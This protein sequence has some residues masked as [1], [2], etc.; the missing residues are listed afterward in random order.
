MNAHPQCGAINRKW[1]IWLAIP[2]LLVLLFAGYWGVVKYRHQHAR[3]IWK[4]ETL[5]Q[6]M[7]IGLTSEV[8][9]NEL[10]QIR[11]KSASSPIGWSNEHVLLMTNGEFL[12]YAFYHGFNTGFIDHLF[13]A[14]GSDGHWYYSTYHFCHSLAGI[15]G[16]EAPGSLAEFARR[17][18]VRQFDGKSEVCLQHTWP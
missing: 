18:S 7:Q 1:L 6:L 15:I 5:T 3:R 9:T 4:D 11:E 12:V 8:V 16:D 2:V 14:Q 10:Q 13:L 17:Y